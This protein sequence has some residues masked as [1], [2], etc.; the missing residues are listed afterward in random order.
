MKTNSGSERGQVLVLIALAIIG[1]VGITGLAID[2]SVILAD[3]RRAQNAADTAALAGALAKIQAQ[4]PPPDGYGYT[5][6][7]ARAPMKTAA[8]DRA[9]SN[10]YY[11]DLLSSQVEVYDCDE[12]D[13]SCPAPYTSNSDYVQVIITSNVDTFFARVLG[14]PQLH[15]RVQAIALA[16]DDDTGPLFDGRSIVALNP[17]CPPSGSLIVSGDSLITINGG[18]MWANADESCAFKCT[19]TSVTVE[20]PDGGITSPAGT[21]ESIS[22]HCGEE[23]TDDGINYGDNQIPYPPELPDLPLP[24]E[25]D[26]DDP[27]SQA[28][29]STGVWAD[30]IHGPTLTSYITPGYYGTFPPKKDSEGNN[31]QNHVFMEPGVYCVDTVLKLTTEQ[32]HLY[33]ED[34]TIWIRAGNGFTING[35]IV[36]LFAS[37]DGDYAGYLIIVEPDYAG[38]VTAC[39]L[40]GNALNEYVGAIYAPHCNVT[41]TGTADTP[42]DGIDSQII[43][44][45]VTINGTSNLTINYTDDNNPG[46]VDPPKTGVTQ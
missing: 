16:D 30:P 3:R 39:N 11:P 13:A 6:V 27:A 29:V 18:G 41:V 1:L 24:P 22:A 42:P 19:S 25:C 46:V 8:L 40:E 15:N 43:G 44:Y 36:Q 26:L 28:F 21:F 14:I 4:A 34:V 35:G 17:D 5:N 9:I 20:I 23:L 31:L 38:S 32:L 45:N 10:G 33:G 2:G 37:N 12:I 7:Q